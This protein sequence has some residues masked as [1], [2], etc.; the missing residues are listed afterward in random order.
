MNQP[1]QKRLRM[2]AVLLSVVGLSLLLSMLYWRN[3]PDHRQLAGRHANVLGKMSVANQF[4]VSATNLR[5]GGVDP[6]AQT[7]RVSITVTVNNVSNNTIQIAPGM[8]MQLT[9]T[10]GS[11][12]FATA[13]YLSAGQTIGGPVPS[14]SSS[15]LS[16]D[17]EIAAAAQPKEFVFQQDLATKALVVEL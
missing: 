3:M 10:N 4:S 15:V 16:V 13:K 8:Q 5:I 7:K 17:F 11:T 6:I 9:D 1:I 2:T 12:T 14:G